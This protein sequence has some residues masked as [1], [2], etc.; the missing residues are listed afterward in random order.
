MANVSNGEQGAINRAIE[1]F[2]FGNRILVLT[3]FA[4]VT[5]VMLYFAVQLRVDAGFRKQVPLLHEYMKTFIDYEREFGGANR[6]LVAVIAKDG[7]MFTPAFMA[8]MDAVTDDVMS[9]DAVDKARVRSIFTPNVR[10]TEVVED[11]F[12]G[13]NVIP[14]DFTQR[15]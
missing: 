3:V 13:G 6:V 10:F 11:G 5:A 12:A 7:N 2:L 9:I 4:L 15:P 8:T 14:S 1:N